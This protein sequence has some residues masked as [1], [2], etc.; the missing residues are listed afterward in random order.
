MQRFPWGVLHN[1]TKINHLR[2]GLTKF[3]RLLI[4]VIL[5]KNLIFG[6]I[7]DTIVRVRELIM[8]IYAIIVDNRDN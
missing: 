3:G 2:N 4:T 8:S 1:M 5:L 7:H 6:D